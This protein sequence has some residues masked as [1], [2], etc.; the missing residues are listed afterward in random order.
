MMTVFLRERES[1]C[2]M[3]SAEFLRTCSHWTAREDLSS[4]FMRLLDTAPEGDPDVAECLVTASRIDIDDEESWHREW[5]AMGERAGRRAQAAAARGSAETAKIHWLRAINYYQAAA[6]PLDECDARQQTL[7]GRMRA[8]AR[9]FL[10]QSE[11][12]GEVVTISWRSD[13]PLQAYFLPAP[14]VQGTAPAVIAFSEPGQCKEAQLSRLARLTAE[15]GLSLLSVDLLGDSARNRF[16][17]IVGSRELESSVGSAM[18][19]LSERSDVDEDRVAIVAAEWGSS[20]VARAI[21]FDQRYAAAACDAGLWDMQERAFLARRFAAGSPAMASVVGASRVAR[22][23]M[24]P[25]LIALKE[26]G[27]LD[28]GH[29]TRLVS[30]MKTHH[31]DILLKVFR[32]S[33]DDIAG[34]QSPDAFVLDW[35][36]ARLSKP[37]QAAQ[38]TG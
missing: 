29:A 15:R 3:R 20:F 7:L 17:D 21:A 36:A 34:P 1:D 33:A 13:Y 38:L 24:C 25:V 2:V 16:A 4:A 10:R 8:C 27:G 9:A 30:Q 19:Y 22:H 12:Q 14:G 31:P 35:I 26:Q 37:R 6:F 32:S 23:I 5:A 11:P 18:D 28:V